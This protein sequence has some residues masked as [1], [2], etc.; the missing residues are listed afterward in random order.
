MARKRKQVRKRTVVRV[1]DL[2]PMKLK[3]RKAKMAKK[4]Y[5]D[6]EPQAET[7][8]VAESGAK[9]PAPEE[10]DKAVT[11]MS[12]TFAANVP[13]EAI[14]SGH[15]ELPENDSVRRLKSDKIPDG[16][17]RVSGHDWIL[18]F[19]DGH[20]VGVTRATPQSEA[21]SYTSIPQPR[22]AAGS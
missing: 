3:R 17:Y 4:H 19:A 11:R 12:E 14:Q 16:S 10:V 5:D 18:D 13:Q 15:Y 22:E 21:S 7:E 6:D 1:S 9:A 20:L 2:R 8:A